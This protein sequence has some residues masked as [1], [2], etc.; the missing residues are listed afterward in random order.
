MKGAAICSLLLFSL[1]SSI[2]GQNWPSFRGPEGSGVAAG[3]QPPVEWD[4]RAEKNIAWKTAVPGLAHSGP[5]VWG[6]RIY[7]TTAMPLEAIDVELVPG[8]YSVG[9]VEAAKDMVRHAWKLYALDRRTGRIEWE[10]TLSEGVP[11]VKRH[12]KASHASATPATNGRYI[13]A[14][15]GSEGLFCTDMDGR[16][17]WRR[18]LGVMDVGEVHEPQYQWGPASSPLI[19]DDLVIV[20][21]DRQSDS[22]LAAY[23]LETGKEVWRAARDERPAWASPALFR[24][25][26]RAEVVTNSPHFIRGYDP[27]TGKELWRFRDEA[28]M[29]IASPVAAGEWLVVTGGAPTG[30]RPIYAFRAGA[31][32]DI[33]PREGQRADARLAWQTERGSPFAPTPL[34]LD[35]LLYVPSDKGVLA[36]YDLRRGERIYQQRIAAGFFSA[37]P[38]AA[39]DRL[40]VTSEEGEIY[41]LRTG[42]AFALLASNRMEEPCLATPAISGDMLIVRT[43]GHVYG[44]ATSSSVDRRRQGLRQLPP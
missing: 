32:G 34:V 19:V 8:D 36:V 42:R 26:G 6:E 20:Q 22:F 28:E 30:A 44:I 15:L 4:I 17:R 43:R 21:N 9:G 35:S 12:R 7:I 10:R 13:V 1:T 40:Y 18:D 14:L 11:R 29:K 27:R 25:K 39:D 2:H 41:V 5:I 16:L 23:E 37:S 38:V 33:S 31:R 24:G 3:A